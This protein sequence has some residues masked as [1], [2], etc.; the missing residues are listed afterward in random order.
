MCI[1]QIDGKGYNRDTD[2]AEIEFLMFFRFPYP[3]SEMF[4]DESGAVGFCL[5][6]QQGVR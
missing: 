1:K 5:L 3:R 2:F 4:S 6:L